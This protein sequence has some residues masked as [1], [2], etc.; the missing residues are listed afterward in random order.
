MVETSRH[1]EH[2]SISFAIDAQHFFSR[3]R[4]LD[5]KG[6]KTMALTSDILLS[7][8]NAMVNEL[9]EC[10]AEVAKKMPKLQILE[11]WHCKTGEAGIFR[12]E[13]LDRSSTVTWQGTWSFDMSRLVEE[14][15]REV[16]TDPVGGLYQLGTEAICLVPEEIA[17]V[18]SVSPYLKLKKH[19]LH[20]ASWT[21]V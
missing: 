6:L 3:T 21:Q 4:Q 12:Y 15:W 20:D 14:A 7:R 8:S 10:V 13:K 5:W 1:L 16:F 9:L 17:G 18:G 11:I 2:L 19:I